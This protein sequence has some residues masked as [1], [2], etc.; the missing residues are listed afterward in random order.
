MY[1]SSVCFLMYC[2]K[3][4]GSQVS[5]IDQCLVLFCVCDFFFFALGKNSIAFRKN[6]SEMYLLKKNPK[7]YVLIFLY[8]KI[9]ENILAI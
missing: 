9:P 7:G 1:K 8:F 5:I 4:N 3:Y 6:Q 2:V